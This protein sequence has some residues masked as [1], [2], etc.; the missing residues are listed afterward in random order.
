MG[1]SAV[2]NAQEMRLR[3]LLSSR[4]I[5]TLNSGF[6]VE[7]P[8]IEPSVKVAA[9]LRKR[10]IAIRET[11]RKHVKRRETTCGYAKGVDDINTLL[12]L[13]GRSRVALPGVLVELHAAIEAVAGVDGPVTPGLAGGKARPTLRCCSP[14]APGCPAWHRPAV[15]TTGRLSRHCGQPAVCRFRRR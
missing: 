7:L 8:G 11:T 1:Q 3:Q 2:S 6:S 10:W 9:D 14:A 15:P 12:R 4:V 5:I 13:P